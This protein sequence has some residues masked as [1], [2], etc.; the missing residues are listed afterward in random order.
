MIK[1]LLLRLL[2]VLSL[3][4]FVI[5]LFA[6]SA[7]N[8]NTLSPYQTSASSLDNYTCHMDFNQ[9]GDMCVNILDYCIVCPQDY[10]YCIENKCYNIPSSA[11]G[12]CGED[13]DCLSG[14]HCNN[15]VCQ[16]TADCSSFDTPTA[17]N[18]T[19]TKCF[20]RV[21][22]KGQS[23]SCV[24]NN[25]NNAG[26]WCNNGNCLAGLTCFYNSY[27]S[28]TDDGPVSTVPTVTSTPTPIPPTSCYDCTVQG[29]TCTATS[30]LDNTSYCVGINSLPNTALCNY[31]NGQ[32]NNDACAS[33]YCGLSNGTYKCADAP[34]GSPVPT[35]TGTPGESGGQTGSNGGGDVNEPVYIA[36]TNGFCADQNRGMSDPQKQKMANTS[37][38]INNATYFDTN[39]YCRVT[40]GG[41]Q[42]YFY[43][44]NSSSASTSPTPTAGP[45][46]QACQFHNGVKSYG[47]GFCG[48]DPKNVHNFDASIAAT[49]AFCKMTYYDQYTCNDGTVENFPTPN[50]SSLCT[51]DPWCPAGA[52]QLSNACSQIIIS[53]IHPGGGETLS[54][55][56]VSKCNS[57]PG[58]FAYTG[59]GQTV[60]PSCV[61]GQKGASCVPDSS[62]DSTFCMTGESC[63]KGTINNLADAY[64]STD[65]SSGGNSGNSGGTTTPSGDCSSVTFLPLTNSNSAA[66]AAA[67][68]QCT[69][70][71]C[72][73]NIGK[74]GWT[75]LPNSMKGPACGSGN[76][77]TNA[78][79]VPSTTPGTGNYCAG[80]QELGQNCGDKYANQLDNPNC[81]ASQ[82]LLCDEP[83]TNG[84]T[85]G[86][87]TCRYGGG[88]APTATPGVSAFKGGLGTTCP[89][90]G[91][92]GYDNGTPLGCYPAVGGSLN[93]STSWYCST[94]PQTWCTTSNTSV[95]S[96]SQCK[97]SSGTGSNPAPVSTVTPTPGNL[98]YQADCPNVNTSGP[99]T[100]RS[101]VCTFSTICPTGYERH[102]SVGMPGGT[103]G[104]KVCTEFEGGQAAICCTKKADSSS[105]PVVTSPPTPTPTRTP[106][107]TPVPGITPMYACGNSAN[108]IQNNPPCP[109]GSKIW[110]YVPQPTLTT[111]QHVNGCSDQFPYQFVCK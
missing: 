69:S 39:D 50:G 13:Q 40:F 54:S 12:I 48:T 94:G 91:G 24:I 80:P 45:E 22:G 51:Q 2:P 41:N 5:T 64:C 29:K 37:C 102:S 70:L 81:D 59:N 47:G 90:G 26:T 4:V 106:T 38:D 79:C 11:G 95:S 36:P 101:N 8:L 44:C 66:N 28:I 92:C 14:L 7:T 20:W 63:Q 30:S 42:E 89:S 96:P 1:N 55:D 3:A 43:Q 97:A 71:G 15:H 108:Q 31:P 52:G 86:S 103:D 9:L 105:S 21:L 58:C 107:A 68:T 32:P 99:Q 76:C 62:P 77:Q 87:Y 46:Q 88:G 17:C 25:G 10:P 16:P 49:G 74:N 60:P 85:S 56:A 110:Q 19:G 65:N 109:Q 53:S 84:T 27:C 75:C 98:A 61:S 78:I 6:L 57:T 83:S 104:T 18:A 35:A 82:N 100:G 34:V 72:F 73:A 111:A 67:V 33:G 93:D 23:G